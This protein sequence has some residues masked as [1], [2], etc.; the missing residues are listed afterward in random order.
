MVETKQ[1]VRMAAL[2]GLAVVMAGC[3]PTVK[4]AGPAV[5]A[6]VFSGDVLTVRD[7]VRLPAARWIPTGPRRAVIIALHSFGDFRQSF[8]QLG[9]WLADR[10][11][12]VYAYDQRG[13][14][15]APH[16][17]LWA[18]TETLVDDLGDAV[19]ALRADPENAGIPLFLLGES[20]GGAVILAAMARPNPPAADGL[21]LAAPGVRE[22][23]PFREG[24]DVLL[25]TGAH[26]VPW[27]SRTLE[28]DDHPDLSRQTAER[29]ATDP[30]VVRTVRVDTYWG[31][32]RL[33]DVASAAPDAIE[34]P[35][36]L[37][38]GTDDGTIAP[39]SICAL[40]ERF[41]GTLTGRVYPGGPHLLLHWTEREPVWRALEAWMA[42]PEAGGVS[43][44]SASLPLTDYCA[45]V[46]R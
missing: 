17:G 30:L 37:L 46:Q 7:G 11:V 9:P 41:A 8:A 36:L 15:A 21:I 3:A 24:W 22:H 39:V 12:A 42:D 32:I 25:W 23:V 14:G 33:A 13:F 28:R 1:M 29:L 38:F 43:P 19:E 40:G 44:A 35:T 34:A 16:P 18:G 4:P 27:A 26:T 31:L 6:P 45:A 10:G 20:M 5:Q 2:I